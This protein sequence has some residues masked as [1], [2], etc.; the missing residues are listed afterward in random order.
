MNHR[1]CQCYL[2][3][4]P[5][6]F[7]KYAEEKMIQILSSRYGVSQ[8]LSHVR[9][10]CWGTWEFNTLLCVHISDASKFRTIIFLDSFW[11]KLKSCDIFCKWCNYS[12]ANWVLIRKA[13]HNLD[14][15]LTTNN[16]AACC[17]AGHIN[18]QIWG[19]NTETKFCC[20]LKLVY[21]PDVKTLR[22]RLSTSHI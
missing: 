14:Q 4:A 11:P 18:L 5:S 9:V 16:V 20:S 13:G 8:A 12:R 7:W 3:T 6:R 10:H 22:Y 21:C 2:L 19:I 1:F 15:E 17:Q